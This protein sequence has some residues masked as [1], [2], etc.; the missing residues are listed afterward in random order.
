MPHILEDMKSSPGG[1]TPTCSSP[2][3]DCIEKSVLEMSCFNCFSSDN[4]G[5]RLEIVK[6]SNHAIENSFY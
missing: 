1:D 5:E 4:N 2:E 3:S 6:K